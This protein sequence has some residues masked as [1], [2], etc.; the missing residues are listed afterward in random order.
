MKF[1]LCPVT[2]DILAPLT[3]ETLL[4]GS[5]IDQMKRRVSRTATLDGNSVFYD[6]GYAV[7]DR[8]VSLDIPITDDSL[9]EKAKEFLQNHSEMT[10]SIPEGVFYCVFQ[11][12]TAGADVL[13]LALMVKSEA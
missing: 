1:S 12:L 6:A 11:D 4:P 13:S 2:F 8:D 9:V 5:D 3:S 7:S 10:L